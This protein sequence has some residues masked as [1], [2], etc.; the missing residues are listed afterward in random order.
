[1]PAFQ[2]EMKPV[3]NVDEWFAILPISKYGYGQVAYIEP[4]P[5]VLVN[6]G[7][8]NQN[9][10]VTSLEVGTSAGVTANGQIASA[11]YMSDG[12]LAQWRYRLVD[13]ISMQL[14]QPAAIGR[15]KTKAVKARISLVSPYKRLGE[16]FQ[17]K[18]NKIFFDVTNT[19]NNNGIPNARVLFSGFR[20]VIAQGN[21]LTGTKPAFY[22]AVPVEGL[23]GLM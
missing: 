5:E 8:I 9:A 15:W 16:F 6:F 4:L 22:S 19:S 12:E 7:P 18:D 17:W 3:A 23:G 21:K 14:S 1:M 11:L 13:D 20:Y 10:T 2:H